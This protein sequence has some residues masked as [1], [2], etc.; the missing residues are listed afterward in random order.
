MGVAE[1]QKKINNYIK[2]QK[3]QRYVTLNLHP[4]D[5]N[6]YNCLDDRDE[7]GITID[8]SKDEAEARFR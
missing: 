2:K 6:D 5:Y 3:K 4:T 1:L 8:D 7:P